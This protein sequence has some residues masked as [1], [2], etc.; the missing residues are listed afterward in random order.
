VDSEYHAQIQE[1]RKKED[2]LDTRLTTIHHD[3]VEINTFNDKYQRE[4]NALEAQFIAKGGAVGSNKGELLARKN[5]LENKLGDANEELLELVS[6]ELP[7]ALIEPLLRSIFET[8]SSE[9]AARH[10]YLANQRIHQLLAKFRHGKKT[11]PK[12]LESFISF[13]ESA[14][15]TEIQENGSKYD[16]SESALLQAKMLSNSFLHDKKRDAK[17]LQERRTKIKA[18]LSEVENYLV[19]EV[20][21]TVTGSIYANIK[22]ITAQIGANEEKKRQLEVEEAEVASQFTQVQR[23]LVRLIEK[24]L[25][26]LESM[27]EAVRI[28]RYANIALQTLTAYRLR[29]QA[30][31][32]AV[33]A[34]KMTECYK[35][36]V[37]K[38]NLI[39]RVEIDKKTLDFIYFDAN[40]IVVDK[41]RLSAGEKQLMVVA[42][43]W[44]LALCS[45]N[46]LPV[47]IDTPLARLDLAHRERMVKSY[48]PY[49]SEQTIILSTDAEIDRRYYKLLKPSIGKKFTLKYDDESKSTTIID[50]FFE[51]SENA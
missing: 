24:S 19:I 22:K 32:T 5:H 13:I 10:E 51:G 34:E 46:K 17:R 39:A 12:Q 18:E 40:G 45:H 26:E 31:K 29:L 30:Q 6:A 48:F 20:D 49:A 16:L 4:I 9:Q 37:N 44:A 42:M 1:L 38:K 33:L 7:L 15:K 21:E 35:K 28:V 36:I 50:G 27:D 47:I 2:E 23:E 43:L 25:S 8:A 3:I 41:K 11:V 14:T